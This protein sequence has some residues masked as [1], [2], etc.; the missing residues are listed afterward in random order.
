MEGT[1]SCL[2]DGLVSE[3][4]VTVPLPAGLRQLRGKE[5]NG[6]ILFGIPPP[7]EGAL[8]V[9]FVIDAWVP[10]GFREKALPGE[11]EV[12]AA[13]VRLLPLNLDKQVKRDMNQTE[14]WMN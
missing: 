8:G 9:H 12:L 4:V 14:G 11:R 3:C 5:P 7:E 2:G 6:S 13:L 10:T 1:D